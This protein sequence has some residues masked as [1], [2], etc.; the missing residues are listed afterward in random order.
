MFSTVKDEDPLDASCDGDG[1]MAWW[2]GSV[3]NVKVELPPPFCGDGQKL[4]ATWIQQFKV[5]AHAQTGGASCT[6]YMA[7]LVNILLTRLDG[8]AF[9]LW[10]SFPTM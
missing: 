1:H 7:I 2:S 6:S 10:D 4:L 8:A 3:S 5:A 9:L